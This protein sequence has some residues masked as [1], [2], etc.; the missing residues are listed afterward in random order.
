[1]VDHTKR[2]TATEAISHPWLLAR[3][4]NLA[5]R[6]LQNNLEEL[7]LFNAK[8]KLRSAIKSVR[9]RPIKKCQHHP[10]GRETNE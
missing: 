10:T 6:D 7:Q 8:R 2:V 9:A 3:G 4:Q 1:M 5:C